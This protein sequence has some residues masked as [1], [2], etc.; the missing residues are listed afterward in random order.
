[1]NTRDGISAFKRIVVLSGILGGWFLAVGLTPA[2]A[3][4]AIPSMGTNVV[5][6]VMDATLVITSNGKIGSVGVDQIYSMDLDNE[7]V[8]TVSYNWTQDLVTIKNECSSKSTLHVKIMGF[9]Y[10]IEPCKSQ[11][12]LLST[13]N[14]GLTIPETLDEETYENPDEGREP[15]SPIAA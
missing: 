6:D 9:K 3:I 4:D 8:V 5:I 2:F 14:N 11:D 1:M 7:T 13:A 15:I 12:V 10:E